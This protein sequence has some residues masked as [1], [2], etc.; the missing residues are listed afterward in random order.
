M[1]ITIQPNG[2]MTYIYND[3]MLD[4]MEEGTSTTRRVS[5]VEPDTSRSNGIRWTADM[6]PVG[7]PMLGPYRSREDALEAEV[8]WLEGKDLN[9]NSRGDARYERQ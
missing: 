9:R 4:L 3:D 2:M 1:N 6:S 7:G 8:R 5:H